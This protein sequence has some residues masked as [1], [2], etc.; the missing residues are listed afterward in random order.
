[1]TDQLQMTLSVGVR[2]DADFDNFYPGDNQNLIEALK[3]Q[4]TVDGQPYIYCW[5][6]S[7]SGKTHLLH[8]AC[9]Y[10]AQLGHQS[11]YL[12]MQELIKYGVEAL[13]GMDALPLVLIDNI[14]L[15]AGRKDWE[16]H[17]FHLFNLIQLNQGHL[18]IAGDQAPAQMPIE[19]ADLASRLASGATFRLASL[20]DEQ[21][22]SALIFRADQ[23]GFNVTDDVAR[24]LLNRGPRDMAGLLNLLE[25][26]DKASL[27]AQ[28]KLTIPFV[29]SELGW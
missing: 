11:V 16:V 4:W 28:R 3:A 2:D 17:I 9:Q 6:E 14:Q 29:K 15:I 7:A 20:N 19:L 26:L 27:A 25:Q 13:Q 12:D 8:A 21:K 1:M 18:I 24:Y 5:G 10:A 22:V 23:R